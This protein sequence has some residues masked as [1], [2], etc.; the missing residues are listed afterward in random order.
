MKYFIVQ[1]ELEYTIHKVSDNLIDDFKVK[2]AESAV[3]EAN[4]LQEALSKFDALEKPVDLPFNPELKKCKEE[5]KVSAGEEDTRKHS[6]LK[7]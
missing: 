6:R 1:E 3:V 5:V 4:D 2:F 7:I